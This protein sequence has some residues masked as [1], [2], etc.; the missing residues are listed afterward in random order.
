MRYDD[1]DWNALYQEARKTKTWHSKGPED[2]NRRA[3]SFADRTRRSVYRERFLALLQPQ[4]SWSVLDVGSG[5]G[6]LA[7]PLAARVRQVT[8]LDF[9]E[10]MLSILNREATR[11][12]LTNITTRCL[13][14]E[15]DWDALGVDRHDVA[16][17]SRSMAVADLKAAILKLTSHA[18]HM[19]VVTDRVRH[20]PFDPDAFAAI[21]RP[22]QTGPDYIYT[23]N[24]LYQ[25]GFLPQITYIELDE[26]LQYASLEEA[27]TSYR[28][29][30]RDLQDQ[31]EKQL[32]SYIRSIATIDS[33]G[34]LRLRRRHPP[35]WAYISWHPRP[36][37]CPAVSG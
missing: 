23:V 35:L 19:V 32:L 18:R 28:W 30:F 24:L 11:Q 29:M 37:H 1:I 6:T 21:G 16:I 31:E 25:Q 17:A 4:S 2:W 5:P 8:A 3:A 33:N 13:S 12:G 7:L 34:T 10:K 9:S 36:G 15:D 20:G 22:L 27:I 14:W 26:V